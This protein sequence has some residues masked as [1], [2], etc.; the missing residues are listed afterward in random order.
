MADQYS[1][2]VEL[3]ELLGRAALEGKRNE[4]ELRE[5]IRQAA[6]L[7]QQAIADDAPSQ[8]STV[9]ASAWERI[10]GWLMLPAVQLAIALEAADRGE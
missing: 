5:C 10:E 8:V 6:T 3:N 1:N 9:S 7:M 4:R 2:L